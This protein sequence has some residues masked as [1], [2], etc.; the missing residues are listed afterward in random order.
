MGSEDTVV[1]D[2]NKQAL[3]KLAGTKSLEVVQGATHL[4]E[5]AG[6]LEQ[7][8]QLSA[9]WFI[10]FLNKKSTSPL[11]SQIF[12]SKRYISKS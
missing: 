5:E 1:L 4:F 11:A 6:A 10:Q 3:E 12:A 9:D 7:V 2:L 8:A